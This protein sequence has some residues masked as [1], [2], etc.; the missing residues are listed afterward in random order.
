VVLDQKSSA[1]LQ[2]GTLREQSLEEIKISESEVTWKTKLR[3]S[4]GFKHLL[5]ICRVAEKENVHSSTEHRVTHIQDL[6]SQIYLF[7]RSFCRRTC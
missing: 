2:V 5:N 1:S 4:Q 7:Q 3:A 6:P